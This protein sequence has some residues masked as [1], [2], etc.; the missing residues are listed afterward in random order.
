MKANT[1][2]LLLSGLP[3]G[4][5]HAAL[6]VDFGQ[7]TGASTEPGYE[8]YEADHE[9]SASFTTRSYSAF[10]ATVGV[11]PDWPNS[12]DARVR[13]MIRRGDA[14]NF[15]GNSQISLLRDWIGVDSRTANGGNGDWYLDAD[16]PNPTYMTLTLSGLPAGTYEW[17]SYHHDVDNQWG[18]FQ[19]EISTDGGTSFGPPIAM[20]MTNS[21][22]NP[23]NPPFADPLYTDATNPD[24]KTLPSTLTAGITADG[25]HDVV[26]RF[27]PFIDRQDGSGVSK[28]FFAMNGFE[29]AAVTPL[30]LKGFTRDPADGSAEVSIEGLPGARYKLVEADD[31]DF[32]SPDLDPIPLAGATVGTLVAGGLGVTTDGNGDATVQFEL[33]TDRPAAFLRAEDLGSIVLLGEDFEADDGGFTAAGAPNDWEWGAPL[34]NN[35][36]D[37]EINSGNAGS[38]KCWGTNL[39]DGAGDAGFI[40]PAA[41]SVLRS[42]DIDLTGVSAARLKFAAAVDAADGT[43]EVLLREAGTDAPLGT[44]HQVTLPATATWASLGPFD[45]SA[46]DGRIVYLV[47]RHQGTSDAYIGFY[48]DDVEVGH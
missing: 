22:N 5:S 33:G 44:V 4:V 17:T 23:T 1:I 10:G 42:P 26:L 6:L 35:G 47:F 39:G 40:D 14:G 12:T 41:D 3:A 18:D 30:V 20:Q 48:I 16:P 28:Q 21:R 34:S 15:W 31:L 29:L 24:P 36:F 46:G 9:Q 11:T 37:L 43:I 32:G 25:T 2:L 27:A 19:L 8:A 13:Q 38:P 7:T 45:L